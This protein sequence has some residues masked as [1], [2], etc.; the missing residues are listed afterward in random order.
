[1]RLLLRF[2]FLSTLFLYLLTK[3]LYMKL[4]FKFIL[5]VFLYLIGVVSCKEDDDDSAYG[6]EYEIND[7]DV[8]VYES[9]YYEDSIPA[10]TLRLELSYLSDN[11][12]AFDYGLNP[13]LTSVITGLNVNLSGGQIAEGIVAPVDVSDYF[14][15]FDHEY[16]HASDLYETIGQYIEG[17]KIETLTPYLVFT[18]KTSLSA[19]AEN[20]VTDTVNISLEVTLTLD[21]S[22]VITKNINTIL[23]P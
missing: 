9:D 7:F 13:Q 10:N 6:P 15:V 22:V 19:K 5:F 11:D 3:Y 20:L 21:N 18:N 2:A 14:L 23:I 8:S 12:Y 4:S 16:F 17:Q 1:M